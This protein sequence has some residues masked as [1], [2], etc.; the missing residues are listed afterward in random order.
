MKKNLPDLRTEIGFSNG[1]LDKTG[2]LIQHVDT[3][4]NILIGIS[5]AIFVFVASTMRNGQIN[6]PL[7]LL[8]FFSAATCLCGLFAIHPPR[9]MRKKGQKESLMYTGEISRC[10]TDLEYCK[11]IKAVL[12]NR[13]KVLM[14]YSKEIYNLSKYY[15]RPKRKIFKFSR[16][17]L[18]IG[19]ILSLLSIV[20]A[21]IRAHF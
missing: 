9:F 5:S 14:Q 4:T 13:D 8:G 11:K 1:I 21:S 12:E 7:V 10:K 15:Y 19:I 16:N 3:Q 6:L 20:Y 18:L 17:L 2:K